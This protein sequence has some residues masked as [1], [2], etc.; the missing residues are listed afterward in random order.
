MKT[1]IT[2]LML[3]FAGMAMAQTN[4]ISTN[5]V[6]E[7]ILK[8]NYNPSLYTPTPTYT[9]QQIITGLWNNLNTDSMLSYLNTLA[10]FYNR[11]TGSDTISPVKGIGA[12]RRWV[13]E[14]FKQFSSQQSNRI[15]P[16]YLQFDKSICG[17]AQHRNIYCVLPG[18]DTSDKS[19][20][21]VEAHMDS[22]C[23]D[24]CDTSCMANGME[25]NGSGTAL[26]IE[27]ARV[28][29][30]YS[31]KNT[32]VFIVT[33]GEEQGLDGAN[34]F[35]LYCAAKGIKIEAV[36][37]NDVIGGILCGKTASPPGCPGENTIDS[38]SMRIFSFGTNLSLQK[39]LAR[40]VKMEFFDEAAALLDIPFTLHIMNAEDRTGR[41]GD[42]IPFRQQGYP[43]IRH[44]S[45]H[46]H[47]DAQISPSYTDRQHTTR[48]VLGKDLNGDQ[49]PDSLYVNLNY[50]KRNAMVNAT[51]MA[52]A[53]SGPPNAPEFITGNDGNGITIRITPIAGIQTYKIGV[54]TTRNDFDTVLTITG[55]TETK[56]YNVKKDT[57][58][59]ISVAAVDVNG[60]ESR[61][62]PEKSVKAVQ[63][64]P[65]GTEELTKTN[66]LELL[67]A[68]P[69]PFDETTTISVMVNRI[70]E[71]NFACIRIA[72][73]QGR[74]IQKLP[75]ELKSGINEVLYEH[76]F[77]QSGTYFYSL[78]VDG[79]ILSTK[80][81][82]FLK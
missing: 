31:Y 56:L 18:T 39:N 2:C 72:D 6:A 70:P 57:F 64:A 65:T 19:V 48:D 68:S 28:M 29:S 80:K 60:I 14:K 59:F 78:E 9:K 24:A 77:S 73:I 54:R 74:L 12:A 51:G 82:V 36:L 49:I 69:N 30:A 71:Y 40:F 67:P 61:F 43:A 53:A 63:Q 21:M 13:F 44:T 5:P 62:A 23:E 26:V 8:G 4:I 11:N 52:M 35:A 66:A 7:D 3:L 37:N 15:I 33:I 50:L 41:G 42:H 76:G 46:E 45:T 27:L 1:L 16:S 79:Q 20:V 55:I 47:G 38:S 34:A 75:L 32:L 10:S 25:D 81:L 17:M 58:Y 22:R